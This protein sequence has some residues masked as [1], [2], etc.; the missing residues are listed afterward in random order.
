MYVYDELFFCKDCVTDLCFDRSRDSYMFYFCLP[1][2]VSVCVLH[3]TRSVAAWAVPTRPPTRCGHERGCGGVGLSRAVGL[4][5]WVT[6]ASHRKET[7]R[8]DQIGWCGTKDADVAI[9]PNSKLRW[10]IAQA[11]TE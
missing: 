11:D 7:E 3:F 10:S 2:I 9:E 5:H 4:G 1:Y 6:R 8:W